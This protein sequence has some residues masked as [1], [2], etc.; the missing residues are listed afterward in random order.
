M[1]S[2]KHIPIEELL[3][4]AEEMGYTFTAGRRGRLM[5]SPA[6]PAP[7]Q[8]EFVRGVMARRREVL[9]YLRTS[10]V[11]QGG[12]QASSGGVHS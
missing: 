4:K 10:R 5:V 9:R 6:P 11:A 2:T 3:R 8:R 1:L 12:S 7:L